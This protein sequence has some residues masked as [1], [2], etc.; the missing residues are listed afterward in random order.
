MTGR[1]VQ[2]QRSPPTS[3]SAPALGRPWPGAGFPDLHVG[4][5]LGPSLAGGGRGAN[6]PIY[7]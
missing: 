5:R 3:M 4:A 2:L 7:P 6:A 1:V